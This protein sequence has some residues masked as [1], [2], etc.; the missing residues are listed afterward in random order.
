MRQDNI[1]K[2]NFGLAMAYDV[3]GDRQRA[4]E[5]ARRAREQF[6][7]MGMKRELQESDDF[8]AQLERGEG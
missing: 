1:A 2:A 3:R 5:L 6:L 8:L 4:E 7:R